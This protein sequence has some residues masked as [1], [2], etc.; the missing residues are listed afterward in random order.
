[1]T[2]AI[3]PTDPVETLARFGRALRAEGLPVGPDRVAELCR[4]AALLPPEG[5][6]GPAGRP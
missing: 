2:D 6:Y 3:A 5:L 1:M 4:A